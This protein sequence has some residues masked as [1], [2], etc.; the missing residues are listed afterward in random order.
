MSK[1][2]II[3]IISVLLLCAGCTSRVSNET[4]VNN[5][6]VE[7]SSVDARTGWTLM[8][9]PV[10][11]T[12]EEQCKKAEFIY[13]G[14]VEDIYFIVCESTKRKFEEMPN[15]YTVYKIAVKDVYKGEKKDYVN[16]AVYGALRGYSYKEKEQMS[17]LKKY[18]YKY[19]LLPDVGAQ[20]FEIGKTYMFITKSS[21]DYDTIYG[22]RC[23]SEY[24]HVLSYIESDA[25]DKDK[26][27]ASNYYDEIVYGEISEIEFDSYEKEDHRYSLLT[28]RVI[29]S[30][31]S[32]K[33]IGYEK[34]MWDCRGIT[35]K[36]SLPFKVGDKKN[37]YIKH[38]YVDGYSVCITYGQPSPLVY[39]K[40]V[41]YH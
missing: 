11:P 5:S 13:T 24:S 27:E 30:P 34:V 15:Y 10:L 12:M 20:E 18:G 33:T 26:I 28:I 37:F 36:D 16:V 4:S 41:E 6:S 32:D 25:F 3:C 7:G 21:G 1:K 39:G 2:S 40:I 22:G 14:E 17:I 9:D 8:I 23:Y 19:D 31:D 29:E 38:D 35:D